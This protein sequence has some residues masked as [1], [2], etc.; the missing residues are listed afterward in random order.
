MQINRFQPMSPRF[1][2]RVLKT[3]PE[4]N[5]RVQY[6]AHPFLCRIIAV[7]M[8]AQ[9]PKTRCGGYS[10]QHLIMCVSSEVT[11]VGSCRHSSNNDHKRESI[12]PVERHFSLVSVGKHSLRRSGEE[13]GRQS[14]R[15]K[16]KKTTFWTGCILIVQ[17]YAS[18]KAALVSRKV[19]IEQKILHR[20]SVQH[21]SPQPRLGMGGQLTA[22]SVAFCFLSFF[23]FFLAV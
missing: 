15:K 14:R 9:Y 5:R 11:V 10:H 2:R 12:H 3:K 7:Q 23:F 19:S 18:I 13:S 8:R 17:C 1:I 22:S 21:T 16:T 4:V 6:E 20:Q